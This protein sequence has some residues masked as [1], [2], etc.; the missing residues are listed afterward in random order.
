[1]TGAAT[2]NG[3]L[4]DNIVHFVRALR[5]AGIRVGTSQVQSAIQAVIATGFTRRSDFYH[6]L[7]STLICREEHLQTFDQVFEMFWRDPEFLERMFQTMLPLIQVAQP[8]QPK[9]KAA[10]RRASQALWDTPPPQRNL[11]E[12]DELDMD[13]RFSWSENEVLRAQDFEQMTADEMARAESAIRAMTLPVPPVPSRRLRASRTGTRPDVHAMLRRSLR[14]GGEIDRL[15][16]KARVPRPPDLV[17]LCDISGS[18]SVYARMMMH[19]L[20]A[21]TWQRN[22]SWG[23]VHGFTFGT[24]LT[25]VTRALGRKDIDEALEALGHEAPDWRGGT[26]IGAAL[27]AF[28]RDWS[29][30]VLGRGAVV[31]LITDGLERGDT[32]LL[33]AEAERLSRSCRRLIWLNPLLRWDSFEPKAQG[34]RIVLPIVDSFHACHSLDSLAD[35]ASSLRGTADKARF[36]PLL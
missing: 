36:T 34:V 31:L 2:H 8:E 22:A 18:M 3:K 28:N 21:L 19:F 13:I 17:A 32:D 23:A 33:R 5:K 16:L 11:P 12:R 1:M 7:R 35:I 9:P 26:R 27:R 30:R 14:R 6:A 15:S 10:Q 20:H 24:R 25:N 4:T 29:R